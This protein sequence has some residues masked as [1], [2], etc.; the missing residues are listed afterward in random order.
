MMDYNDKYFHVCTN[1]DH[2]ET[3]S[4]TVFH[5]RQKGNILTGTYNGGAIAAGQLIGT[6]DGDGII[7]MRYH[8][9]NNAGE[10]NTGICKSTPEIMD[11]GK[12]RLH[13][14]WQ[15]TSGERQEGISMI[16]EIDIDKPI[17]EIA[18]LQVKPGMAT[19]FEKDF[20]IAGQ[21]ISSIDGYISHSIVKCI[22]VENKYLLQA[23]WKNLEDHIIG[24]RQSQQY[25]KWKEML[26]HYYDPFP[27]VEHY[28]L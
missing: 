6:I 15:W 24:F 9:V 27:E 3:S 23:K 25:L 28:T 5:Y 1:V 18:I 13:E 21:Y 7:D 17:L 12:I 20:A 4:E 8:Q 14:R 16:E 26:H 11:N 2:G 19:Q 10:V 22:E